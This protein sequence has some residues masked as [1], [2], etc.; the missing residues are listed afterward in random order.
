MSSF[1]FKKFRCILI[2]GLFVALVC[3]LG[4][5]TAQKQED[6]Q[7]RLEQ[8][9]IKLQNYE[10][11]ETAIREQR[12][13]QGALAT[14]VKASFGDPDDIFQSGSRTGSFEIWTYEKVADNKEEEGW[15]NIRLYFDNGKLVSWNF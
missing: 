12:L 5:S 14:D 15:E 7:K 13:K 9:K 1:T 4:C 2:S 6:N 11:L 10:S 3:T 8:L